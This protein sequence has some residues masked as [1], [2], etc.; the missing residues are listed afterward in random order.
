MFRA[1][2]WGEYVEGNMFHCFAIVISCCFSLTLPCYNQ[3]HSQ[4]FRQWIMIRGYVIILSPKKNKGNRAKWQIS[5][6]SDLKIVYL[7][8]YSCITCTHT[9]Y[10]IMHSTFSAHFAHTKKNSTLNRDCLSKLLS[11]LARSS[12]LFYAA[13]V[14]TTVMQIQM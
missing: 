9:L 7:P 2:C 11:L 5:N 1:I 12:L 8:M 4:L 13:A 3:S 6:I 14:A 10:V